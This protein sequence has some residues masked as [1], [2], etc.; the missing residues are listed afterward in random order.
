MEILEIESLN[1]Y[2]NIYR[3]MRI[4]Q[5]RGF[6]GSVKISENCDSRS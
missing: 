5:A 4:L 2:L 6:N 3:F 1:T